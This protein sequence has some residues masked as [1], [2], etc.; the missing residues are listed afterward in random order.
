MPVG[1]HLLLYTSPALLI[2]VLLKI[3]VF[4]VLARIVI[5]VLAFL[6]ICHILLTSDFTH[7]FLCHQFGEVSVDA[8][9]KLD[10]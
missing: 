9:Q 10:G 7:D 8:D 6:D 4:I 1:R 5:N 3:S 2:A